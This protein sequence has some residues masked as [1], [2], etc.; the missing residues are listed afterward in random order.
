MSEFDRSY[1]SKTASTSFHI[2]PV[3]LA[4]FKVKYTVNPCLS[5]SGHSKGLIDIIVGHPEP[6]K[7][8]VGISE[9]ILASMLKVYLDVF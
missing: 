6:E 3:T 4:E 8:S 1:L 9:Y 5:K 7:K 2:T